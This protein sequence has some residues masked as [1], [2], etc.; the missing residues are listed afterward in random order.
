M[1]SMQLII[2]IFFPLFLGIMV[3]PS[4][5]YA[6][7][8]HNVNDELKKLLEGE[9]KKSFLSNQKDGS[10]TGNF[11]NQEKLESYGNDIL[12]KHGTNVILDRSQLL[13]YGTILVEGT[14]NII[15]TGE[16]PLR[17]QKIIVGLTG[18]LNIGTEKFP[19]E[20]NKTVEIIFVKNQPGEIGIFV[21]GELNIH[22]YDLGSAFTELFSDALP[23]QDY[24]AV[25]PIVKEWKKGSKILIT[26]PGASGEYKNCREENKILFIEGPF[27]HLKKPLECFHQ[28][29]NDNDK[30]VSSH[31]VALDRNIVI[32]SED[33]ENR[34]STNFFHGSTGYVK[35]AEFRDLGPKDVLGRY[36]IHFHH[37]QDS[38]IG[39]EV[40]G[41][42]ILNSDNRW[43]TIHDSNGILVKN[44][45]G[46]KSRGHGFFLEQGTEFDNIFDG[47]IGIKTVLGNL[48]PSDAR[49]S[50]FWTMNPM[51]SFTNNV[52]VDGGYYGFHFFIPNML[53]F[54]PDFETKVNLRSL[55]NLEFKNNVS[56]NNKHAGLTIDRHLLENESIEDQSISVSGFKALNQLGRT[57]N[58]WGIRISGQDMII[59]NSEIYDSP[60][61][62]QL[63]GHK[64][65]VEDTF[66]KIH[67]NPNQ[68]LL[69][70]GILISG[71]DNTIRN[72]EIEGY[73]ANENSSP[74][75]IL[76]DNSPRESLIS[77]FII[78]TSLLDPHPIYFG[79]PVNSKS[80]LEIHGYD[81]PNGPKNNYP[82]NFKL[83]KID[84]V[85]NK[86]N[87]DSID[88]NFMAK[89]TPV[90]E[91]N[92]LDNLVFSPDVE[93]PSE[94]FNY[95][96]LQMFK[97][98][99]IAWNNNLIS[100]NEFSTEL[101]VMITEG[102]IKVSLLDIDNVD[103]YDLNLPSWMKKTTNFWI[104]DLISD[105]EIINAIEF[106]L[107][108]NLSSSIS[109]YG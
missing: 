30:T 79:N 19:I 12:I 49:A 35:F 71:Q 102:I 72:S 87:N 59:N 86:P 2:W 56:Y 36:P 31:V 51:N 28:G 34:G 78:D 103:D 46:Y 74:Y 60:I 15:E 66:I 68:A 53:V 29:Y 85:D 45:V 32:R 4:M 8:E 90:D 95:E 101:Q 58:Q 21:F 52:A 80:F 61:G 92:K 7:E 99:A 55:P 27:V 76:I 100:N 23:G 1:M 65:I 91:N 54:V 108:S 81:A 14:L 16:K 20:K 37:M 83:Q 10:F 22:G 42:S 107:E 39:I 104:R 41:N 75:D 64:N 96:K 47:N 48:I 63:N 67:E 26:S 9:N 77:A 24:L 109:S 11:G 25:T 69:I 33:L 70:G 62:I 3:F 13:E 43:I 89:I 18:K 5:V 6:Q 38:S 50:V 88:L 82:K 105:Q 40:V 57:S 98:K 97:N 93:S 84:F 106:V 17:V 73:V 94:N 44:N